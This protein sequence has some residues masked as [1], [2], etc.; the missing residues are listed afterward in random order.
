MISRSK[1]ST[2]ES[3][4]TMPVTDPRRDLQPKTSISAIHPPENA[5][6]TASR[7]SVGST[8]LIARTTIETSIAAR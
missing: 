5:A 8:A 3:V 4:G 2:M 6:H 1:R 7:A